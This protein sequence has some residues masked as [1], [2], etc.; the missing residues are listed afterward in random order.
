MWLTTYA[1][2]RS[3]AKHT[4]SFKS[5]QKSHDSMNRIR[6]P[7]AAATDG[8]IF[9]QPI[10]TDRPGIHPPGRGTPQR[11]IRCDGA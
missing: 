4:E 6:E 3:G 7:A 8:V 5:S 10:R 11:R 2:P 9:A 1:G